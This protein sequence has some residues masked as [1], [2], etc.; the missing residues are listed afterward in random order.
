MPSA[1]TEAHGVPQV[2]A[3]GDLLNESLD[4]A[5]N[6]KPTSSIE[7]ALNKADFESLLTRLAPVFTVSDR[8]RQYAV[9][10]TAARDIFSNLIVRPSRS[11][12]PIPDDD[13]L[14]TFNFVLSLGQH[15]H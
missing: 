12:S 9:I 15:D 5:R 7:P 10:E 3:V 14:L 4:H 6:I 13:T 2:T 1:I 8:A 11:S